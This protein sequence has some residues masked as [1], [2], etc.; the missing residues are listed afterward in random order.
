MVLWSISNCLCSD[1]PEESTQCLPPGNVYASRLEFSDRIVVS[2]EESQNAENYYVYKTRAVFQVPE[3]IGTTTELSYTDTDVKDGYFY[4]YHVQV[5]CASPEYSEYSGMVT[6]VVEKVGDNWASLSATTRWTPRIL[7]NAL[8]FDDKLWVIGGYNGYQDYTSTTGF[9]PDNFKNEI[10]FTDDSVN[11]YLPTTRPLFENRSNHASDSC[12][13]DGKM[14]ISGGRMLDGSYNDEVWYSSDGIDW[15]RATNDPGWSGRAGHQMVSF[16]GYMW[17]IGGING[18]FEYLNDVWRSSDGV[19][20]T[21][22]TP[23]APFSGR[24]LFKALV[25]NNEIWIIGGMYA[26]YFEGQIVDWKYNN[27][28]WHSADGITWNQALPVGEGPAQRAGFAAAVHDG[29]M[30]INGGEYGIPAVGTLMVTGEGSEA[31]LPFPPAPPHFDR[32]NDPGEIDGD[33]TR[34]STE[35]GNPLGGT[36][37]D[38]YE[39]ENPPEWAGII[40]SVEVFLSLRRNGHDANARAAILVN[41]NVYE[42]TDLSPIVSIMD[43]YEGRTYNWTKN[44]DT[45]LTWT[46]ANI[47]DIE[48]GVTLVNSGDEAYCTAV[49]IRVHFDDNSPYTFGFRDDTWSSVDGLSWVPESLNAEVTPRSYHQMV[50]YHDHLILLNGDALEHHAWDIWYR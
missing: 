15:H 19:T 18:D 42:S 16:D 2:W 25:F 22:M 8:V 33:V 1:V 29:R 10:Y 44:P 11:W 37:R 26:I 48:A 38:L 45:G 3:L 7:Y 40:E 31:S 5:S 17:V 47:A 30:W 41:G 46:W 6:G 4:Y 24:T 34:V 9:E 12:V 35:G 49:C 28:V 21:E 13:Y 32:V 20:W 23:N 27:E 36:Y 14:W 50:S 43:I 39:I